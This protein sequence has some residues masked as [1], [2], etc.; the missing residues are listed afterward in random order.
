MTIEDSRSVDSIVYDNRRLA[1]RG[2][3]CLHEQCAQ[4]RQGTELLQAFIRP[5]PHPLQS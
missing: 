3:Y 5:M 2:F 4:F 1:K